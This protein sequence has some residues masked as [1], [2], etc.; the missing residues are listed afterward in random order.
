MTGQRR[1]EGHVEVPASSRRIRELLDVDPLKKPAQ[2]SIIRHSEIK[3]FGAGDQPSIVGIGRDYFGYRVVWAGGFHVLHDNPR[4]VPTST[5]RSEHDSSIRLVIA[6]LGITDADRI[7]QF[8]R[9]VLEAAKTDQRIA[10]FVE[11]HRR[12]L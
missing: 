6:G 3:L 8:R 12:D 5:D 2:G 1:I 7:A 9:D 11:H 10:D 4:D